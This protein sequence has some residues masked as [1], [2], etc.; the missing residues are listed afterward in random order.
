[1][2]ASN[3]HSSPRLSEKHRALR[4]IALLVVI[5]SAASFMMFCSAYWKYDYVF[6]DNSRLYFV[7]RDIMHA[8]NVFG[9]FPLWNPTV[10]SGFP[11]HYFYQLGTNGLTPLCALAM[12]GVWL[13]GRAGLIVHSYLHFYILYI[14]LLIPLLLTLA[15]LSLYVQLFRNKLTIIL[16]TILTQFSPGVVFNLSDNGIEQTAYGLIYASCFLY[17][18][19]SPSRPRFILLT[20]AAATVAI[21]LNHLALY[22]NA[23]FIPAFFATVV[24]IRSDDWRISLRRSIHAVPPAWWLAS[25]VIVTLM[26]IPAIITYLSNQDLV[27][28]GL[29]S[30]VY[31]FDRLRPGNPL[32]FLTGG[33]PGGGW[34]WAVRDNTARWTFGFYFE[35]GFQSYNYLGF[36]VLPLA[37]I[38]LVAGARPWRY[39]IL[40]LLSLFALIASL[41]AYSG[42]FSLILMWRS[43]LQ[44]VNHYSDTIYRNGG[45]LILILAAGLGFDALLQSKKLRSYL[46]VGLA[47][48]FAFALAIICLLPAPPR[49]AA[50]LPQITGEPIVG[51]FFVNALVM[52]IIS[53]SWAFKK[54]RAFGR[55]PIILMLA[56]AIDVATASTWHT[57]IMMQ[58]SPETIRDPAPDD[59]SL[60]TNLGG[61]YAEI[62]QV[63]KL[64]TYKNAGINTDKFQ[65]ID[66]P[67]LYG[68][69]QSLDIYQARDR[70]WAGMN[71]VVLNPDAQKL[72]AFAP[73]FDAP[74]STG[75]TAKLIRRTNNSLT[76]AVTSDR[77]MLLFVR[78][79]NRKGWQ[80]TVNDAPTDIAEAFWAF[81]AVPVPAGQSTVVLTYRRDMLTGSVILAYSLLVL[82]GIAALRSFWLAR[83]GRSP[84]LGREF[85]A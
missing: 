46:P 17:Y 21:S 38:G 18:Y 82:L 2:S 75:G 83:R 25:I 73:F 7:F 39:R 74:A 65:T 81:K 32:E 9:E 42:P 3:V 24:L 10:Q 8:M 15:A 20:L 34:N 55:E 52:I 16:V 33:I 71:S 78:D 47:A 84:A 79:I 11:V 77:P 64:I 41:S 13:L 12:S 26:L 80:A 27:R 85:P 40:V 50:L 62:I 14:G 61:S 49:G 66:S 72:S 36:V 31:P 23:L 60:A 29:E 70:D 30:G 45:F 51:F 43:P 53:L 37:V 67:R 69:A 76:V 68:S 44:A 4:Q 35:W 19:N 58:P 59:V 54:G 56:V 28:A 57:R 1:M 6:W 22:W 63:K 5:C 48:G